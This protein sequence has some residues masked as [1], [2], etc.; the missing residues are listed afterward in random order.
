MIF[1]KYIYAAAMLYAVLFIAAGSLA[2]K[3]KRHS[4]LNNWLIIL[5]P[6]VMVLVLLVLPTSKVDRNE[7]ASIWSFIVLVAILMALTFSMKILPHY[8]N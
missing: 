6:P 2:D 8:L 3:K 5:F 4:R 1:G 7:K